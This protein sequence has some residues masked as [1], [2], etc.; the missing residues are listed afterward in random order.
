MSDL[1]GK[2]EDRFSQ[3]EAHIKNN[4][5]IKRGGVGNRGGG[6][7]FDPKPSQVGEKDKKRRK[8]KLCSEHDPQITNPALNPLGLN[9]KVP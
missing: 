7:R 6:A 4:K 8:K 5:I 1:V 2:P 3:N 9:C